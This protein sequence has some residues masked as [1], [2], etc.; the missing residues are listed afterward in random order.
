MAKDYAATEQIELNNL[1]S[2]RLSNVFTYES[3]GP[4]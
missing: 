2:I 3:L 4:L 1:V